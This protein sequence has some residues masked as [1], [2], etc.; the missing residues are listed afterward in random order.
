VKQMM[1]CRQSKSVRRM[2]ALP[3]SADS[4][5]EWIRRKKSWVWEQRP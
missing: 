3:L 5:L 2:S 4:L 1:I